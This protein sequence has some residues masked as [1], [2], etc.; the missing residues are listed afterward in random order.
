MRTTENVPRYIPFLPQ[1]RR[2]SSSNLNNPNTNENIYQAP[3]QKERSFYFNNSNLCQY[4]GQSNIEKCLFILFFLITYTSTLMY[5]FYNIIP[6]L[7]FSVML[8]TLIVD[9]ISMIIY[10]MFLYKLKSDNMFDRLPQK[11]ISVNDFM[12]MFNSFIK[13]GAIVFTCL[14]WL[15]LVPMGLFFGKFII[16]VYFMMVSVKI[17]LFCPGSRYVQEQ[18]EKIWSFVKFYVFCC[19]E[20]QDQDINEYTKIEDIESFY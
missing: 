19:E 3:H 4:Y 5:H 8:F 2:N 9:G 10:G 13:T 15:G 14:N 16:E 7:L 6:S 18:S 17:F 1:I 20:E 11:L 12:V